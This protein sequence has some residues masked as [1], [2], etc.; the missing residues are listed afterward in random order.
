MDKVV[1]NKWLQE[2]GLNAKKFWESLDGEFSIE[3]LAKFYDDKYDEYDWVEKGLFEVKENIASEKY[4][5]LLENTVMIKVDD[6]DYIERDCDLELIS[7]NGVR[8][9]YRIFDHGQFGQES[10]IERL[11]DLKYAIKNNKQIFKISIYNNDC[12][13]A[14]KE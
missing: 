4:F 8:G 7:V 3:K 5:K 13:Y 2:S 1:I 12:F 11:K 9:D 10:N 6:G 14:Y